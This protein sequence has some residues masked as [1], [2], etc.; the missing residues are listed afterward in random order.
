MAAKRKCVYVLRTQGRGK[1]G[2]GRKLKTFTSLVTASAYTR[3]L[4]IKNKNKGYRLGSECTRVVQE[5]ET[6]LDCRGGGDGFC[7]KR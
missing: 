7:K 1:A 5:S 6:R 4:A 2:A 3:K